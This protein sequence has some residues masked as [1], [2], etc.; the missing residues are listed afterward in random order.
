MKTIEL[1][2]RA[3]NFPCFP[4]IRT[5]ILGTNSRLLNRYI[6]FALVIQEYHLYE[7]LSVIQYIL[8]IF[9]LY[10]YDGSLI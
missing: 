3:E 8:L 2:G 10:K 9:S 1:Q 5:Q 6:T 7:S 4:G